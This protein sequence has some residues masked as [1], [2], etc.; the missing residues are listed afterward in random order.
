MPR[1]TSLALPFL[2]EANMLV[3]VPNVTLTTEKGDYTQPDE[4]EREFDS[5]EK[6]RPGG[7][8]NQ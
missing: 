2:S 4:A 5:A 7:D 6:L 8:K 3:A 1:F